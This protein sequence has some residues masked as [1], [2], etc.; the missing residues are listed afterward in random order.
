[1]PAAMSPHQ[2][3]ILTLIAER[4]GSEKFPYRSRMELFERLSELRAGLF[5]QTLDNVI[6]SLEQRG[7]VEKF[8][9]ESVDRLGRASRIQL[10]RATR[11]GLEQAK[12]LVATGRLEQAQKTL[13]ARLRA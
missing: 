9:V 3:I 1:M 12:S 8:L 7:L 6:R 4:D 10:H 2:T 13:E 5:K 11:K